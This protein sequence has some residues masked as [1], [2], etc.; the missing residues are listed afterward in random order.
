MKFVK[1]G[2]YKP[3]ALEKSVEIN[4]LE[5]TRKRLKHMNY[6]IGFVKERNPEVF[7][8][9]V[10]NLLAKYQELSM[11]DQVKSGPFDIDELVSDN[12]N[13]TEHLEL[14]KAMLSYYLQVLQLPEDANIEKTKF[15][16]K[17]YLQSFLH[18]AYFNL[19]VLTETLDRN[20]AIALYKKFVTHY[21]M[22]RRDPERSTYD[23]LETAFAEAITPKEE[24]S[25]WVVVRGMIGDGKYAYRNDNCLWIDAL[26]DLPD[27]ELKYYVCCYGDYE[28]S[29]IY[30]DSVILTMEHT[31]AQG[32]PYCSRVLHDTRVD[33]DLKHPP[34]DFWDSMKPE[35]E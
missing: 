7:P 20:D 30:H 19:L 18:P 26:E 14:T 3:D 11:N 28:S 29:K 31:I 6:L 12:P 1:T 10:D 22:D 9:Y 32:N 35:N 8:K 4:P 5:E 25:E 16:N 27:S 17:N 24:P 13:L 23:N 15:V 33:W 21:I 2:E 34:K